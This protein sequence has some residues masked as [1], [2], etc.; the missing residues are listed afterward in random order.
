M[1]SGQLLLGLC[2]CGILSACSGKSS[3][4]P[5]SDARGVG[6]PVQRHCFR[7]IHTFPDEPQHQDIEELLVQISGNEASGQFNW[8]PWAKDRRLGHF[9]GTIQDGVIDA[10]YD[11]EQE[12]T[13]GSAGI[14]IQLQNDKAIVTGTPAEL[15]LDRTMMRVSCEAAALQHRGD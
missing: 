14:S 4:A 9:A 15:G 8:I 2:A 1:N 3:D 5:D 10:R 7:E 6:A 13:T 12:G 11:F